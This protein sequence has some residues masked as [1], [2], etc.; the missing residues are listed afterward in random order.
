MFLVLLLVFIEGIF[1][2]VVVIVFVG[3]SRFYV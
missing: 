2:F 3:F 1:D